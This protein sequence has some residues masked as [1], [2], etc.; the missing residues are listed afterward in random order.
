MAISSKLNLDATT[1]YLLTL[2]AIGFAVFGAYVVHLLPQFLG[3]PGLA[4]GILGLVAF[5]VQDLMSEDTPTGWPTFTTFIAVSVVGALE[6]AIGQTTG[7]TFV[8]LAG[9][10]AW[11]LYVVQAVIAY[12]NADQGA[13]IP[14]AEE[15]T[16]V[17]LLGL[18]VTALTSASASGTSVPTAMVGLTVTGI[19]GAT[20]YIFAKERALAARK[21][22]SD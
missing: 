12:L 19:A 16:L 9:F 14:A 17:A 22:A 11:L 15:A 4:T 6:A 1:T 5:L 10:L 18:V 13:N 2:V 8:T 3:Y 7:Q 21:A 20:T